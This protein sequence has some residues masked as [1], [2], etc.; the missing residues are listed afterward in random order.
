MCISSL[1]GSFTLEAK[2]LTETKRPESRFLLFFILGDFR[3]RCCYMDDVS[4]R[5]SK[6]AT[7]RCQPCLGPE[8]NRWHTNKTFGPKSLSHSQTIK[9]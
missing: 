6:D 4:P 8:V 1:K 9:L 7:F 5:H 2:G 3:T